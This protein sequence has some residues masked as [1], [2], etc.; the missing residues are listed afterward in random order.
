MLCLCCSC[1]LLPSAEAGL[2][3]MVTPVSSPQ[4]EDGAI[5]LT[6]S[7]GF[8]PFEIHWQG[9][10]GYSSTDEDLNGLAPGN[11]AVTV[12]DA[13]CGEAYLQVTVASCPAEMIARV[14]SI[15]PCPNQNN[16]R[17]LF[18]INREGVL[19]LQWELKGLWG[20]VASGTISEYQTILSD[21]IIIPS[22]AA[23]IYS[24]SLVDAL[25]CRDDRELIYLASNSIALEGTVESSCS[26]ETGSIYLSVDQDRVNPPI[27]YEWS[28]GASS[29]DRSGLSAGDYCVTASDWLGCTAEACFS[30]LV[31]SVD[32]RIA[33]INN[34]GICGSRQA[35][36]DLAVGTPGNYTYQWTGPG[37]FSAS[38]QDISNLD[39]GL[40]NVTVS[41]AGACT[42]PLS[43]R[44][45]CCISFTA[46]GQESSSRCQPI[47]A[48]PLSLALQSLQ[49]IDENNDRGSINVET[50]GGVGTSLYYSWTG[51]NGYEAYTEDISQ[52]T[53]GEYCLTV[54]D[55]CE[56]QSDCWEIVDCRETNWNID[57]TISVACTGYNVGKIELQVSGGAEPY[58]YEW[59]NGAGMANLSNLGPGMYC[60]TISDDNYCT[61]DR[62]WTVSSEAA[63]EAW[64]S[65]TFVTRCGSQTIA[66]QEYPVVTRQHPSRCYWVQ[67]VC[68][69]TNTVLAQYQAPHSYVFAGACTLERYNSVT[70]QRCDVFPGAFRSERVSG[71]NFCPDGAYCG[72][73]DYC[74]FNIPDDQNQ[75]VPL[76]YTDLLEVTYSGV[77]GYFC[78]QVNYC[79]GDVDELCRCDVPSNR[80]A[81]LLHAE[82]PYS[83]SEVLNLAN[84]RDAFKHFQDHLLND[85]TFDQGIVLPNPEFVIDD[86]R[87][88]L[89]YQSSGITVAMGAQAPTTSS[90]PLFAG[91]DINIAPTPSNGQ[92]YIKVDAKIVEPLRI[93]IFDIQGQLLREVV[94]SDSEGLLALDPDLPAGIYVLAFNGGSW[95][96]RRKIIKL[97]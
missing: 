71:C 36:I 91:I 11:Y 17:L 10:A 64:E 55:G 6:I 33:S 53:E 14:K 13:L 95:R 39:N 73:L 63:T 4:A 44:I 74:E 65:C 31:N 70:G 57:A 81:G 90:S 23:G 77:P 35:S 5:D 93:G 54:T 20:S 78:Q 3:A 38:T 1:C 40:Y 16:G 46:P 58:R 72:R 83:M 96:A 34:N 2:E 56:E 12:T 24:F 85:V 87:N 27:H 66:Q 86:P 9:P 59:S 50:D 42:K 45:C 84:D 18:W 41:D 21:L 76:G 97:K 52:L 30:L 67:V 88:G 89:R 43:A 62:C 61:T 47:N 8:A 68:T 69:G 79:P 15:Y 60:V 48:P 28:D 29:K 7:G 37:G 49:P 19:P 92:Y 80:C 94:W 75:I 82:G 51:P 25:G 26:S 32:A 22:L